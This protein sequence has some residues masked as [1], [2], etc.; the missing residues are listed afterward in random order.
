M[1]HVNIQRLTKKDRA[2]LGVFRFRFMFSRWSYR[3]TAFYIFKRVVFL[4]IIWTPIVV[5]VPNQPRI[6]ERVKRLIGWK[7]FRYGRTVSKAKK[8]VLKHVKKI[9]LQGQIATESR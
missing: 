6:R 8:K 9:R 7:L 4:W 5:V 1:N 2:R 3:Q